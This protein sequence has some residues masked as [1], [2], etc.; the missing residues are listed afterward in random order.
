MN[1][2]T[3]F[4]NELQR[5]EQE[6]PDDDPTGRTVAE[7][8]D[9]EGLEAEATVTELLA[10]H[11]VTALDV[12]KRV[13][14][15]PLDRPLKLT[16]GGLHAVEMAPDEAGDPSSRFLQSLDQHLTSQSQTRISAVAIAR[17]TRTSADDASRII[18]EL[19]GLGL[20]K[21][22]NTKRLAG[23]QLA[24]LLEMTDEG[25]HAVN[26]TR[27]QKVG[28]RPGDPLPDAYATRDLPVLVEAARILDSE[29]GMYGCRLSEL[30]AATGLP[31]RHVELALRA[32]E[33]DR[34]LE[35][36]WMHPR[37]A[38]R[39]SGLTGDARRAVKLWPT[40]ESA[41]D[42]MIAALQTIADNT[43]E[44]EDTRGRA[45]TILDSFKGAGREVAIA[46]VGAAISG[47]IPGV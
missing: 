29:A 19:E 2:V 12:P 18:A 32:L 4:L 22:Y 14:D 20:I 6:A 47:Q 16:H 43:D 25:K 40:P 5:Q 38:S 44:D 8:I 35:V 46:V 37:E 10:R 26:E 24:A 9:L 21:A 28:S 33:A 42:R 13:G 11:L 41:L 15:E 39:V 45:R 30:V 36:H 31:E 17:A 1:R 23:G 27:S 34:L 3:E 7:A